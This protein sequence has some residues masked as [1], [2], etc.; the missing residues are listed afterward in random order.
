M[1]DAKQK[2]ESM[3]KAADPA[4]SNLLAIEGEED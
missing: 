4:V 2:A 1:Q 3:A